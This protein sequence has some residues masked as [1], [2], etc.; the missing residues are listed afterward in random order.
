MTR[1][2]PD[3]A[4]FWMVCRKPTRPGDRTQPQQRY[5]RRADAETAA[6]QLAAQNDHPFLILETVAVA[7]P[8]TGG[9]GLFDGDT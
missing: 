5:S 4:R 9:A 1:P 6:R 3:F 7:D 2:L 8:A